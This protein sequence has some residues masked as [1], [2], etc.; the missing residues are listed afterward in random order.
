MRKN[1]R[2]ASIL[3]MLIWV[4]VGISAITLGIK[5]VPIYIDDFAV[6]SS[7]EG[8]NREADLASLSNA[9]ILSRLDKH[10]MVNNVRNFDKKNIK[11]TR[12][13]TKMRIDINYEQRTNIIKN[14][15]AAVSFQHQLEA[16]NQ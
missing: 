14:I 7:L 12:E 6:K 3:V 1:Q 2:G 9:E 16:N 15:D 11:I 8:L 5:L 13:N 10:F 4:V